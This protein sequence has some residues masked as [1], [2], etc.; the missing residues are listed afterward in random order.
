MRKKESRTHH[1]MYI[2]FHSAR[3][4]QRVQAGV[5]RWW[6]QSRSHSEMCGHCLREVGIGRRVSGMVLRVG[7]RDG[8]RR[9]KR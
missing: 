7:S 9:A 1:F 2:L 8:A 4:S 6:P 3:V 5:L